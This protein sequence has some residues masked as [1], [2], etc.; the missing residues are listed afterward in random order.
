M[1]YGDFFLERVPTFVRAAFRHGD[2][3]IA[4][5]V[6]KAF[7]SVD[8]TSAYQMA[9]ALGMLSRSTM[10]IPD[11]FLRYLRDSI[12]LYKKKAKEKPFSLEGRDSRIADYYAKFRG[13]HTWKDVANAF[14]AVVFRSPSEPQ[15]PYRRFLQ[16]SRESRDSP[17]LPKR[18]RVPSMQLLA[19]QEHF[20][21]IVL[22]V[23]VELN[24]HA[25]LKKD[26]ETLSSA[27]GMKEAIEFIEHAVSLVRSGMRI[28]LASSLATSTFQLLQSTVD[29]FPGLPG[30]IKEAADGEE[31]ERIE[32]E[33][34]SK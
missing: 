13:A 1:D 4:G 27:I 23:V 16:E 20:E 22:D 24:K 12:T 26:A 25:E 33:E 32:G 29:R 8:L 2:D 11:R 21:E 17:S 6:A 14:D 34:G 19:V 18:D 28:D 9:V 10:G 3:E 7:E 31:V 15:D 30:R 5:S